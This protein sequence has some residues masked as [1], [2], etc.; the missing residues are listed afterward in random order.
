MTQFGL[1]AR[2]WR[3]LLRPAATAGPHPPARA[4]NLNG[5]GACSGIRQL[6]RVE[7]HRSWEATRA[8]IVSVQNYR[9]AM[10]TNKQFCRRPGTFLCTRREFADV[11]WSSEF[12]IGHVIDIGASADAHP[13]IDPAEAY[14]TVNWEDERSSPRANP[15][16]TVR[17]V[18]RAHPNARLR[19]R[20]AACPRCKSAADLRPPCRL[21][22]SQPWL[23]HSAAILLFIFLCVVR[24]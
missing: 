21:A 10:R 24:I 13:S 1:A 23:G 3:T 19:R 12:R 22:I 14:P 17:P 8:L 15:G 16:P 2:C 6:S 20:R 11:T 7:R 18:R 4:G 9:D 5:G